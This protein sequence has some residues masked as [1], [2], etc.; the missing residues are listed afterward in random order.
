[1]GN[2]TE[3]A[4][5]KIVIVL[6]TIFAWGCVVW[7]WNQMVGTPADDSEW[8]A[9]RVTH[10]E[11]KGQS[12][13]IGFVGD[14]ITRTTPTDGTTSPPEEVG[15]LLH[16]RTGCPVVVVNCG[17]PGYTTRQLLEDTKYQSALWK[18]F[19]EN[20]VTTVMVCTG[21]NDCRPELHATAA[22]HR[23]YLSRLVDTLKSHGYRAV[24]NRPIWFD[25]SQL[26]GCDRDPSTCQRLFASYKDDW[27][28][29]RG[30][31]DYF[32]AHRDELTDGVHPNAKGVRHLAEF[33][34]KA[35]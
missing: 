28:G 7:M 24:V 20:H 29:D 23:R 25:P 13:A 1:M 15:K 4:M 32:K 9:P 21:T 6:L 12:V 14:S 22:E 5:G 30:A 35:L 10:I 26:V 16:E 8:Y 33:W 3:E 17:V 2:R 31:H 27:T 19:S 18:A 34:L 11:G